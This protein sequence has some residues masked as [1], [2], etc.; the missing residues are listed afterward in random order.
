MQFA[1]QLLQSERDRLQIKA[2]AY[3][4]VSNGQGE[5]IAQKLADLDEALDV[6]LRSQ[7]PVAETRGNIVGVD[8][9]FRQAKGL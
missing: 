6:L 1:L 5:E 9:A 8:V 7:M 3:A 4:R 2:A